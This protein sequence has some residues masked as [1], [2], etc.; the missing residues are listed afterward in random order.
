MKINFTFIFKKLDKKIFFFWHG[1]DKIRAL[2]CLILFFLFSYLTLALDPSKDID[3]Y[4]HD[5]WQS[6]PGLSQLNIWSIIQ[7]SDHYIWF[8]T[9]EGIVRFDGVRF[10]VYNKRNTKEMRSNDVRNIF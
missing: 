5:V 8:A 3:Q 4:I 6:Q 1:I 2:L 10:T 9:Q 7:T